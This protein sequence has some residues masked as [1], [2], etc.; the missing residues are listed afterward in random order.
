MNEKRC[1]LHSG[2][3][4]EKCGFCAADLL[5]RRLNTVQTQLSAY[6]SEDR[7]LRSKPFRHFLAEARDL[8]SDRADIYRSYWFGI[9]H[10]TLVFSEEVDAETFMLLCGEIQL[11]HTKDKIMRGDLSGLRGRLLAMGL[12]STPELDETFWTDG[13]EVDDDKTR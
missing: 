2:H 11:G 13:S 7:K 4:P 6:R 10:D 5:L 9:L 1:A 12:R 8:Y 3:V